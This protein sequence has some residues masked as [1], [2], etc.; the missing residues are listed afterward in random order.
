MFQTNLKIGKKRFELTYDWRGRIAQ[1]R[2]L[3]KREDADNH[4]RSTGTQLLNEAER[5]AFVAAI[6]DEQAADLSHQW[7]DHRRSLEARIHVLDLDATRLLVTRAPG[8]YVCCILNGA[9]VQFPTIR[10]GPVKLRIT[11]TEEFPVECGY[12]KVCTLKGTLALRHMR[13]DGDSTSTLLG[14]GTFGVWTNE[15][16]NFYFVVEA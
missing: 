8:N 12:R 14:P 9:E 7:E 13:S 1:V 15:N 16:G 2:N 6:T 5:D 4:P 3:R 10:Q 11:G